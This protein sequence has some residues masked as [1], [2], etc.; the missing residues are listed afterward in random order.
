[1]VAH[2]E[3]LKPILEGMEN[4]KRLKCLDGLNFYVDQDVRVTMDFTP[5]SVYRY[6]QVTV[7]SDDGWWWALAWRQLGF[8][9]MDYLPL[10]DLPSVKLGS[11]YNYVDGL[12]D[13]PQLQDLNELIYG[14]VCN[15]SDIYVSFFSKIDSLIT[16]IILF[17]ACRSTFK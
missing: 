14:H 11:L 16:T 13:V 10:T 6:L 3:K 9:I 7:I 5:S 12:Q 15:L 4:K 8:L 1:M 17:L 2:Q